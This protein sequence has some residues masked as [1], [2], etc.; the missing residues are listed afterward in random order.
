MTHSSWTTFWQLTVLIDEHP[1]GYSGHVEAIQKVL[2][3]VFSVTVHVVWFLQ[4]Q[5]ALRHRF[6]HVRVPV[7]D[8]HQLVAKMLHGARRRVPFL[9]LQDLL[10]TPHVP[11]S[12]D[13]DG[14]WRFWCGTH[15]SLTAI[16]EGMRRRF[17]GSSA[18]SF[19]MFARRTGSSFRRKMNDRSSDAFRPGKTT[20]GS[21]EIL[22][23]S[24]GFP[25]HS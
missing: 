17:S 24:A 25:L 4:L 12:R 15:Q 11:E 18:I 10:K 21:S 14:D 6:H 20:A 23:Y 13:S 19:M 5:N 9:K 16:T 2:N 22:R 7:P 3:A 8:F 1:D